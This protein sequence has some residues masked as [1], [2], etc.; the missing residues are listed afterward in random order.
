MKKI[1]REFKCSDCGHKW[2]VPFGGGRQMVCPNCG[3]AKIKRTNPC[4]GGPHRGRGGPK[5]GK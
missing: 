5:N 2:D 4:I 3:Q 1:M